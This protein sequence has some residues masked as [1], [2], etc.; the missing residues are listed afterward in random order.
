MLISLI[1][2]A[3]APMCFAGNKNNIPMENIGLG[4]YYVNVNLAGMSGT[5]FMV[6][7]GSGYATIN[8]ESLMEL[9]E[10]NHATY[11]RDIKGILANGSTYIVPIW[12]VSSLTLN[13]QCTLK[14]VEVAVFPGKTRQILGL[15]ALKKAAPLQISFDPPQLVL[16]N[17]D[18]ML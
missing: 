11:V 8:E 3:L 6:D 5:Q 12:R 15:S 13:N 17:C 16:S 9:R 7:T 1:M 18:I 2:V 10:N 14:N 4:T